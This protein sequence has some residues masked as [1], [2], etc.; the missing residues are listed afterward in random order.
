MVKVGLLG[1]NSR[2]AAFA[3]FWFCVFISALSLAL[4]FIHPGFAVGL[5][6]LLS[7]L[8]YWLCIRWV[9]RNSRWN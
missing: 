8:W 7:A 1:I 5:L 4:C 2:K 3:Y 9:D 6:F